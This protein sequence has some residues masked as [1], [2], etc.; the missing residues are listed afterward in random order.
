MFYTYGIYFA[1][2]CLFI[3][4]DRGQIRDFRSF[5]PYGSFV[6]WVLY[7]CYRSGS[8]AEN[9]IDDIDNLITIGQQPGA[10]EC[11]HK[12]WELKLNRISIFQL[13][14]SFLSDD[15]LMN[16]LEEG[17]RIFDLKRGS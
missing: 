1:A 5:P 17:E 8:C 16:D 2:A 3:R 12:R 11:E 7:R 13:H 4:M 14:E 15:S 9:D 6:L 10:K